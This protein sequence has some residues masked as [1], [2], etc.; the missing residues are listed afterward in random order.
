MRTPNKEVG[1]YLH[2]YRLDEAGHMTTQKRTSQTLLLHA[3]RGYHHTEH[4]DMLQNL[5]NVFC[6]RSKKDKQKTGKKIG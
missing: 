4:T 3:H 6:L 5:K 1:P 2:H